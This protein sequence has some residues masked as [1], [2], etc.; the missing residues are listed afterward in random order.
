LAQE[1]ERRVGGRLAQVVVLD[2]SAL[3]ALASSND[4]HHSWALEMFRDTAGFDLQMTGLTQAEVLVHPARAGKLDKFLK[5]IGGLGLEVTSI[6]ES[7]SSSIAKI[8]ASTN[9]KMPD[10]IVLQQ[11]IKVNGSIAT[12]DQQLAKVAKS[13]GVEVFFPRKHSGSR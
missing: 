7:D 12:T 4:P 9:L 10:V 11:A 8:R 13:K 3:I 1:L 5:L 2:A 6:D